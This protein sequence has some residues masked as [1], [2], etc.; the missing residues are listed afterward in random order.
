MTAALVEQ[1][2]VL[3]ALVKAISRPF[4]FKPT[5]NVPAPEPRDHRTMTITLDDG[6]KSTIEER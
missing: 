2:K 1:S 4:E 3:A 5:I 6:T